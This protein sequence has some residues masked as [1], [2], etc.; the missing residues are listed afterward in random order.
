[1]KGIDGK[2]PANRAK[3][4]IPGP[5]TAAAYFNRGLAFHDKGDNAQAEA[6]FDRAKELGYK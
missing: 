4:L 3:A 6:D 2:A 5:L 1:M